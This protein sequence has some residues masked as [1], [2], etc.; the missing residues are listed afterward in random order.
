MSYRHDFT[1]FY[2]NDKN[3]TMVQIGD[4]SY[5]EV[6]GYS[7]IKILVLIHGKWEPRTLKYILYV[8]KLR[9]N[10][11]SIGAA[12]NKDLKTI[13][14]KGKMDIYGNRLLATGLKQINQCYK[15]LF[16]ITRA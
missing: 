7:T 10:V 13:F 8:P 9:K 11:F 2:K 12:T 1:K 5:I 4:A 15:M 3:E 14:N 16:K 6:E